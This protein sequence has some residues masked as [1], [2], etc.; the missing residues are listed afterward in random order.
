MRN[1]RLCGEQLPSVISAKLTAPEQKSDQVQQ[2]WQEINDILQSKQL[3]QTEIYTVGL[4]FHSIF[5]SKI[6]FYIYFAF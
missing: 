5:A 1:K 6:L 2:H 4:L 3:L